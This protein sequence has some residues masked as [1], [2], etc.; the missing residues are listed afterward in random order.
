MKLV[1]QSDEDHIRRNIQDTMIRLGF[2]Q[3]HERLIYWRF[4][5]TPKE[6]AENM[7]IEVFE[8]RAMK[9]ISGG[10]R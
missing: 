5:L 2:I 8:H 4:K 3:P 9:I 10:P 6:K 1:A 7:S